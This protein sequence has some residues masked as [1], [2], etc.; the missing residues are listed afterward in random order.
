MALQSGT[1]VVTEKLPIQWYNNHQLQPPH[2][3]MD[4]REEFVMWL[5][6]EFAAAN[7]II[8]ALCHH[9]RAVGGPG[10]YD[11]VIM[12]IQQRR[13]NWNPILHMQQFFPVAEVVYSLQ[14]VSWRQQQHRAMGFEGSGRIGGD[15][16]DFRREGRGHRGGTEVHILGG[17]VNGK[18][19][20]SGYQK[21]NS[22]VD[23][24]LEGEKAKV[25]EKEEKKDSTALRQQSVQ[26][27]V[28]RGDDKVEAI[29]SCHTDGSE[30]VLEE[31]INLQVCPRTFVAT[32]ICEGKPVNIA[33]GMKLYEDLFDDSEILKLGTLVNDLRASGRRGQLKGQAFVTLKRPMKGHGREIIQLGVPI[34]DAR[35]DDEAAAGTSKDIKI[36]PIPELL[37]DVIERLLTEKVVSIKPDSTIIDF[38]NEGDYSQPHIWPQSFGK[39]VCILFLTECEMSFGKVMSMDH[40]GDYR[41]ALQ[42]SLSPGSMLVVQG[43]SAD[44]TRHAISSQ[45]KQRIVITLV[46]SQPKKVNAS[47][48][49]RS[50]PTPAPPSNWV[51]TPSRSPSHTRVGPSPPPGILP[52]PTARPQVPL[53]NNGI[54]PVFVPN[55][56]TPAIAFPAPI[57]ITPAS[58]GWAPGPPRHP[59]P[60]RLPVPGTGVFLPPQGS[61]NSLNQPASILPT[62]NITVVETTPAVSEENGTYRSNDV[63]IMEEERN[64]SASGGS[65][66]TKEE[67]RENRESV[68]G[69]GASLGKNEKKVKVLLFPEIE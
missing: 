32:E 14:Q 24:K 46:K 5:R 17:E 9:L 16:K 38:F 64:G 55:H 48:V 18:D 11:G 54:Q 35:P 63:Q 28:T 31:R 49:H 15:G 40:P 45:R 12:S 30:I 67:E 56:A 51:P 62:E 10:E 25:G 27:I 19:Q 69:N 41:G 4:E 21:S 65:V 44:F 22:N 68:E 29:V 3:Q 2:H 42:L 26:R 6:G 13:C 36:E 37:Q 52:P 53:P 39:P 47:D 23:E 59:P 8:D 33:E 61:G 7:A 66:V 57:A 20:N 58:V 50:P 1:V 43:R 60:P 34:A